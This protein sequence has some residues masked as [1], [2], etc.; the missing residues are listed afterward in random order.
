[1]IVS[2]SAGTWL[3]HTLIV[4]FLDDNGCHLNAEMLVCEFQER[5]EHEETSPKADLW[6][7]DPAG[8][9]RQRAVLETLRMEFRGHR[10]QSR[11]FRAHAG[12]LRL[13]VAQRPG[14]F[15]WQPSRRGRRHGCRAQTSSREFY[16]GAGTVILPG[17]A[18]I[19]FD[20]GAQI[21]GRHGA[22]GRRRRALGE[23]LSESTLTQQTRL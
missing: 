16:E 11:N 7:R 22:R 1:M 12:A 15:A 3:V 14:R 8:T 13:G 4:R 9:N 10:E 23:A 20:D 5:F 6:R 21:S 2:P 17:R 18:A 19:F